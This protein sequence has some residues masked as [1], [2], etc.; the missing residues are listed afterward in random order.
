M[1]GKILVRYLRAYPWWLAGVLVFQFA[2]AMASST[3][4]G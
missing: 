3:C 2:S 4:R 1:L